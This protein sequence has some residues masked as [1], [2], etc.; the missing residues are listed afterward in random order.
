MKINERIKNNF[1]NLKKSNK[2]Y[3]V[4]ILISSLTFIFLIYYT[5]NMNNLGTGDNLELLLRYIKVLF[6]LIP[7]SV[8][9]SNLFKKF[10]KKHN[11]NTLFTLILSTICFFLLNIFLKNP[12]DHREMYILSTFIF[13]S[14]LAIFIDTENKYKYEY[15][16][17]TIVKS[18]FLTI[19]YSL[20]LFLGAS[21][22]IF[23][24]NSLFN[25]NIDGKYHLYTF[26]FVSLV[27]AVLMFLS[28]IPKEENKESILNHY[29][30]N[31][32][33]LITYIVIPLLC[34]Y[35]LILYIYLGKI[36]VTS[37]WPQG[38]VSHL[39][40]WYSVISIIVL[41]Y[42]YPIHKE[43]KILTLF[44]KIFPIVI[45]PVYVMM[46]ISINIRINQY[47]LTEN[48]YLVVLLGIWSILSIIFISFKKKFNLSNQWITISL[49]IFAIIS[50]IGPFSSFN[51]SNKS[52]NKRLYNILNENNMIQVEEIIPNK[53]LDHET[54]KKINASISYFNQRGFK[55]MKYVPS[56]FMLKDTKTVFGFDHEF[57]DSYP[58]Y[59]NPVGTYYSLNT[60][61]QEILN[62]EKYSNNIYIYTSSKGDKFTQ[63]KDNIK[64]KLD[65]FKLYFYLDN[66][67]VLFL[68]L[69]EKVQNLM[70]TFEDKNNLFDLSPQKT[71]IEISNENI[72]ILIIPYNLEL[73]EE[74]NNIDLQYLEFSMYF[75]IK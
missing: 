59:E 5:E 56:D 53:N 74:N 52:Q 72:D 45:L 31:L 37:N 44:Y 21:A 75:T 70:S 1:L 24:I 19:A 39:I 9:I 36:L 54:E 4:T 12:L 27:F 35:T 20:I 14:L 22:I 10:I 62:I 68:D 17:N 30:N 51:L 26:L 48:R 16:I 58:G 66:S 47:G 13:S 63:S 28:K 7:L 60:N 25:A 6:I 46:F 41:I 33:I 65:E 69:K 49:I 15:F 40:L 42:I 73:Y 34:I 8:F 61:R 71:K 67:E 11:F 3:P 2:K 32:K 23:T 38:I 43:N 64:I 50:I 29:S 57:Y 18:Y 55:Y